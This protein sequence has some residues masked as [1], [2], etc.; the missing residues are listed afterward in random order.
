MCLPCGICTCHRGGPDAVPRSRAMLGEEE[1]ACMIRSGRRALRRRTKPTLGG[2]ASPLRRCSPSTTRSLRELEGLYV[3]WQG[4]AVPEPRLLAL[5]EQLAAE[6]GADPEALRTR[7]GRGAPGRQR[8]PGRR[9]GRPGLR[10]PSVRRVLPSP[11]RW[12]RP[13]ARRGPRHAGP[14]PR[15]AP[16]GLGAH[17]VRARRRRQGRGR[18]DAARVR[19]RRGDACARHPDLARAR[20]GRHGRARRARDARCRALSSRASRPATSASARSSTRR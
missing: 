1:H 15:P 11:G 2:W 8:R 13:A 18:P 7:R 6:L 14:S 9:P 20:R 10:R 5:N 12:P 17:A 4:A 16:Q 3:P 19:D